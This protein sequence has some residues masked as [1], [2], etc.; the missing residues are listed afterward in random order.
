MSRLFELSKARFPESN[1]S[2]SATRPTLPKP[3]I[4][5]TLSAARAKSTCVVALLFAE[6]LLGVGLR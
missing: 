4:S 3:S 1:C 2:M 5:T 6:T